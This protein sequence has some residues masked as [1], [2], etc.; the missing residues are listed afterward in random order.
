MKSIPSQL[1]DREIKLNLQVS[2]IIDTKIIETYIEVSLLLQ[3]ENL[4]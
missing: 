1:L 2:V 3:K 4:K